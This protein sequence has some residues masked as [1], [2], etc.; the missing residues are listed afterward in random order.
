MEVDVVIGIALSLERLLHYRD[1]NFTFFF[2]FFT[3]VFIYLFIIIIIV[4]SLP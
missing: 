4:F 1:F 2:F 3:D